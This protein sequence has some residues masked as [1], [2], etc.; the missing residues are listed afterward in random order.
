MTILVDIDSTITNFGETLLR[1]LNRLYGTRHRYTNI[2][3]YDWFDQTFAQPWLPTE[4]DY[5][6]DDVKVNPEAVTTIESWIRQG[7][8]VFLV[9]ASH[10]NTMLSYKIRKTL[11]AFDSTLINQSNVIIAQDKS[12]IQGHVM[13]DDC[14]DNLYAFNKVRICY[15][16]PWN[17]DFNGSLRFSDWDK[18]NEAI[19]L[20]QSIYF[21][22]DVAF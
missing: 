18:I 17:Q 1:Y 9:T 6:W 21:D 10:F 19:K 11:E 20:I 4:H 8:K 12:A 3:S 7:H 22:E 14:V 13:I 16:Q 5:F 15:T 2:T